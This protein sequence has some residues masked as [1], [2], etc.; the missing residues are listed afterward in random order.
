VLD[1]KSPNQERVRKIKDWAVTTPKAD[2]QLVADLIARIAA[3]PDPRLRYMIGR[4][5]F[6]R[7]WLYRL[8]PWKWYEKLV[9]KK[10]GLG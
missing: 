7:W 3:D 5:A 8:L 4:D 10:I 1:G 9:V 6:M 2:P